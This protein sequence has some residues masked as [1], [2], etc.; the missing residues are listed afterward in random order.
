MNILIVCINFYPSIGG[1]ETITEILSK[2]FVRK[3]HEVTIITNTPDNHTKEFPFTILRNPSFLEVIKAY[4]KC[5]VF[6]HQVMSLKYIWPLFL[7]RKPWFVVYHQVNWE[8]GIKGKIKKMMSTFSNNICVSKTTALGYGLRRYTIINNAYNDSIFKNL[9][10]QE[11]RD[12]AFVGRLSRYKGLYLLIDAFNMFKANTNSDCKL[13]II[14]DS[15]ERGQ[16]EQY[17]NETRYGNDIYF[18]GMR[19]P[20]EVAKILNHNRVLAVTS[21][22]PYLEA[23]GIVVLEGL[24]CGCC[25]IGSSGDGI[26]EALNGFGFVYRNGDVK[27]LSDAFTKNYQKINSNNEDET[28]KVYLDSRSSSKVAEEYLYHFKNHKRNQ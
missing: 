3:G 23:F 6:V 2:E 11:R 8:Y 10:L 20:E 4:L 7:Y 24:A 5:D 22:K 27:S 13:N 1:L 18:W 21:T 26:E 25:V 17:A 19:T 28:L 9:N 12:I 14:G 16:I 15:R